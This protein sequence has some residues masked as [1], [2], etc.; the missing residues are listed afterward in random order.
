MK[1]EV[2]N[3]IQELKNEIKWPKNCGEDCDC[4]SFNGEICKHFYETG[5]KLADKKNAIAT[6]E[7]ALNDT[8]LEIVKRKRDFYQTC[9][10][11]D[12]Y[13][14]PEREEDYQDTLV[15]VLDEIIAKAEAVK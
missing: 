9:V 14:D 1:E 6:I 3:A 7:R 8:T 5:C 13:C 10:E 4:T 11:D 2:R 12:Y 15:E